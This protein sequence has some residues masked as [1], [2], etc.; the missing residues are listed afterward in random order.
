[1][2][3]VEAPAAWHVRAAFQALLAGDTPLVSDLARATASS[4]NEVDA[5]VGR[6][7]MLDASGRVVGAAGLSLI[8]A[9]QHRLTL[10]GRQYWTWCAFDAIGIPAGLGEDALA[11]T[12]CL[13][14]GTPVR[15]EFEAGEMVRTSHAQARVWDAQRMEGRGTL[16]PP[17]C[18]LMNLFCSS[19]QLDNWRA[20]HPNE[21]GNIRNLVQVC[22]LGRTEWGALMR[23]QCCD[24]QGCDQSD[25]V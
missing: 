14:C 22:E 18:A 8:S 25:E 4:P 10:R 15:I 7:L 12:T 16:G 23:G 5:L 2:A 9:R 17:H 6:S 1:M 19:E 11:E 24:Q 20:E 3:F 13:Q 21:Q